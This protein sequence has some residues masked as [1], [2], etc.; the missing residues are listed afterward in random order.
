MYRCGVLA[1]CGGCG[2]YSEG[3]R[4][5]IERARGYVSTINS[6]TRLVTQDPG[7]TR[8]SG[9]KEA[10][11]DEFGH[12]RWPGILFTTRTTFVLELRL[13]TARTQFN[14]LCGAFWVASI[15]SFSTLVYHELPRTLQGKP[16]PVNA[17]ARLNLIYGTQC[18]LLLMSPSFQCSSA[19]G[20]SL[21][22]VPC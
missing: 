14:M 13:G 8:Q 4:K 21:F 22:A 3:D 19:I 11:N 5:N 20:V 10:Q 9:R 17:M 15:I 18:L 6:S 1:W 12:T 2:R 16:R 7:G